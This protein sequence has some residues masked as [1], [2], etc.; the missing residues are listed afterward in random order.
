MSLIFCLRLSAIGWAQIGVAAVAGALAGGI[1]GYL[2]GITTKGIGQLIIKETIDVLSD[3]LIGGT[4]FFVNSLIAGQSI[5]QAWQNFGTGVLTGAILSATFKVGSAAIKEIASVVKKADT[6]PYIITKVNKKAVNKLGKET[7]ENGLTEVQQKTIQKNVKQNSSELVSR[8]S[9]INKKYA[10]K[11]YNFEAQLEKAKLTQ[12]QNDLITYNTL[13]QKYPNGVPFIEDASGNV[14][15][16]FKDYAILEYDFPPVTIKNIKRGT[17]LIGNSKSGSP[18]FKLF[19]DKMIKNGYSRQQISELLSTHTIHHANT[20]TL[21]LVPRDL[22]SAVSHT[23][24][25]AL[26]RQIIREML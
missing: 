7:L 5:D 1:S 17:C 19:R 16:N 22:H 11:N 25:A 2:G 15:P 18:D 8:N 26:I 4:E 9:C 21:Q 14:L 13:K 24:G 12:N 3:S 6:S 23:G 10:G 20:T